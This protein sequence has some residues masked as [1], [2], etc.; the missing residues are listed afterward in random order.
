MCDHIYKYRHGLFQRGTQWADGPEMVTQCPICPGCRY[1]YRYNVTGQEGTLWWHAHSSMLR[2]TVH[3]AIVIRPR[4]GDHGYPFPKPHKEEII[5][6]GTYYW[7]PKFHSSHLSISVQVF[8]C[9]CHRNHHHLV[10]RRVVEP[11]RVR[12]GAQGLP[13]RH[14]GGSGRCLHHQWRAWGPAQVLGQ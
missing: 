6:L 9:R 4:N 10:C 2:A 3:G 5:M 14:S 12:L 13:R 1:T 7:P 8:A 11:E